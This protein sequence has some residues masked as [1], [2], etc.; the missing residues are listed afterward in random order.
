[1]AESYLRDKKRVIPCASLCE[2]EFGIDEYFIGVPSVIGAGGVERIL[3]FD[4]QDDEKQEL[5]QTLTA[6]QKT[7]GETKL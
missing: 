5:N 3:E 7:V 4:L 6:V 2:G 1:M